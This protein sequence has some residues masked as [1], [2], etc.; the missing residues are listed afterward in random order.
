[1]NEVPAPKMGQSLKFWYLMEEW[2][3]L[4]KDWFESNDN[5]YYVIQRLA[6]LLPN[7]GGSRLETSED[8]I[9]KYQKRQLMNCL[10]DIFHQYPVMPVFSS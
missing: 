3:N 6:V 7:V 10:M 1:M 5:W 9:V 8:T 4:E 2:L